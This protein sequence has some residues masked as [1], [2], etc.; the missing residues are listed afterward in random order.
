MYPVF[1]LQYILNTDSTY[2]KNGFFLQHVQSMY[3]LF[4]ATI[5]SELMARVEKFTDGQLKV[6]NSSI[7]T[8]EPWSSGASMAVEVSQNGDKYFGGKL[9]CKKSSSY[10]NVLFHTPPME[11]FLVWTNLY[12]S[13]L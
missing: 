5:V 9:Q 10:S 3:I 12:Y 13:N 11:G 6:V 8:G 7:A 1:N 2:C 4:A